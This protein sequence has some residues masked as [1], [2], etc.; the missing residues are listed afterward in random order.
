MSDTPTGVPDGGYTDARPLTAE[1][2]AMVVRLMPV[3]AAVAA[4]YRTRR[5]SPEDLE[6]E[7]Y[8]AL[9]DAVR[10]WDPAEH[11]E[12][13]FTVHLRGK[14]RARL[15][16]AIE[17]ANVVT[18]PREEERRAL[19]ADG[20]HAATPRPH[21]IAVEHLGVL[22]RGEPLDRAAMAA[23][24]EEVL[25][26]LGDGPRAVIE[27]MV[28]DGLTVHQAA[29]RLGWHWSTCLVLHDRACRAIARAFRDRG[30]DETTWAE[31]I[32]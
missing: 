28:L 9:I 32:A 18:G 3:A 22:P 14:V 27:L 10:G 24:V 15:W 19:R 5:L 1:Q 26:A 11:P 23:L 31:A 12:E 29:R 17:R 8:L 7:A 2:Q 25:S 4:R 30:W 21:T 6:G 16:R 20:G 13:S